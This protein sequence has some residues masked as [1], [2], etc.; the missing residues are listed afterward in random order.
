MRVGVGVGVG[1]R[2]CACV[3]VCACVRALSD[4]LMG[5]TV[6][7]NEVQHVGTLVACKMGSTD[8]VKAL[9]HDESHT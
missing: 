1:V 5:K 4:L 6:Q 7:Q 2:A 3:R 8:T 9:Q